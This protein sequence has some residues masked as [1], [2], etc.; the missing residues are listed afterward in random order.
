M[1]P[2]VRLQARAACGASIWKPLFGGSPVGMLSASFG[3]LSDIGEIKNNRHT[4]EPYCLCN[5][6]GSRARSIRMDSTH[7]MVDESLG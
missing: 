6:C 2:N 1:T 4:A 3:Y 7:C 5:S